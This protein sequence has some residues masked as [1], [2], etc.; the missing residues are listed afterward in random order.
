LTVDFPGA[1]YFS[2]IEKK[3]TPGGLSTI[4]PRQSLLLAGQ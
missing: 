4:N 1:E 3:K 2:G